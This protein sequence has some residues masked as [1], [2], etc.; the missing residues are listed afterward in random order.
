MNQKSTLLAGALAGLLAVG[1]GAFGSHGLSELLQK[2]GRIDTYRLAV[3]YQ[4]Y[5]ALA[6]LAAG[7]LHP[8]LNSS[9]LVRWSALCFLLGIVFFSGSL[10]ILSVT[11]VKVLG[12]I[13]PIG[14]IFFLSGWLLLLLAVARTS[15]AEAKN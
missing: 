13:T 11:N 15:F 9:R 5:H 10:Y 1:I 14:G 3:D 2:L 7:I 8:I 4:F 6:M 12:A